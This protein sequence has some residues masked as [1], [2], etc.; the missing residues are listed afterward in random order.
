MNRCIIECLLLVA[1]LA[2]AAGVGVTW[3][4]RSRL[5]RLVDKR[6]ED[7][8]HQLP[9]G[10]K[11]RPTASGPQGFEVLRFLYEQRLTLFNTRREYEWKIYFGVMILLG[12]GDASILTNKVALSG[13]RPLWWA[14]ACGFVV[15]VCLYFER[16]LQKRNATDRAAMDT[17]YNW[18]CDEVQIPNLSPAR[19]RLL[20]SPSGSWRWSSLP[21][22]LLLIFA[23][24]VS[25]LLP[26]VHK[27]PNM[28]RGAASV[29]IIRSENALF[30]G[31]VNTATGPEGGQNP[32]P[33][34]ATHREPR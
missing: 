22:A 10:S 9:P 33:S 17:L 28:E 11:A 30:V 24:V 12:A 13:C 20:Y 32:T 5:Y 26:W 3:F 7:L 31:T 34:P 4:V 2:A 14:A 6:L 16:Q 29:G 8:K 25:A 1:A 19:E 18:L 21:K 23:G 27:T 15:F